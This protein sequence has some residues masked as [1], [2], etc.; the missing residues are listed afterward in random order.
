[1]SKTTDQLLDQLEDLKAKVESAREAAAKP[2]ASERDKADLSLME[3]EMMALEKRVVHAS[4]GAASK[5]ANKPTTL[6]EKIERKLDAALKDSFPGSDPVSFVEAAPL[7][8]EDKKLPIVKA[9]A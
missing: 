4:A 2:D 7:K 9:N 1:M 6:Q 3:Q 8:P 5:E